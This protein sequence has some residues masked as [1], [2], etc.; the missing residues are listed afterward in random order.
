MTSFEINYQLQVAEETK[1]EVAKSYGKSDLKGL[2]VE[3]STEKFK[4]GQAVI[5][6]LKDSGWFQLPFLIIRSIFFM[7]IFENRQG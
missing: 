3:H 4:T 2:K 5:L 1:K 7:L 6:T